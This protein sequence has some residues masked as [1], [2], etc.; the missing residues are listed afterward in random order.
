ML[1]S[2]CKTEIHSGITRRA[3]LRENSERPMLSYIVHFFGSCLIGHVLQRRCFSG[4]LITNRKCYTTKVRKYLHVRIATEMSKPCEEL[5]RSS[6]VAAGET[7]SH[8]G[9]KNSG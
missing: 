1:A 4:R 2:A 7:Q 6:S 5:D 3:N 8:A 9:E